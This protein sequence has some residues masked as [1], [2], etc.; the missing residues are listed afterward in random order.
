MSING[1]STMF[2]IKQAYTITQKSNVHHP[3]NLII[4]GQIE[5]L[6]ALVQTSLG[7][8]RSAL[9]SVLSLNNYSQTRLLSLRA[10]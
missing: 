6:L 10:Y 5:R 4:W 1:S 9:K 7:Q 2:L 3:P 8:L